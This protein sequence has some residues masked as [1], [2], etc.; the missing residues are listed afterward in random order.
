MYVTAYASQVSSTFVA[1]YKHK[2]TETA[3]L[4]LGVLV[5]K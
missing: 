2:E 1:Y 3:S 5:S 4:L